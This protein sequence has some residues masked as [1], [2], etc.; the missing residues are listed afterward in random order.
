[1]APGIENGQGQDVT[2]HPTP[3]LKAHYQRLRVLSCEQL[4]KT[5]VPRFEAASPEERRALVS[6]IRAVG[7]VFSEAGS[8]S[9]KAEAREWMLRLLR[10]PEEKVR[11]YAILALPKLAS[12]E[13]EERA[14][15]ECLGGSNSAR[16]REALKTALER[17][18]GKATLRTQSEEALAPATLQRLKAN[19]ARRESPTSIR[20][21]DPVSLPMEMGIRLHCRRGIQEILREEVQSSTILRG[22]VRV[23]AVLPEEVCLKARRAFSLAELYSLRTFSAVGMVLGRVAGAGAE[24]PVEAL[25]E[26]IS[27]PG[28]E[29][30]LRS[31]TRGPLR[32]RLE[33][34]FKT[35][36]GSVVKALAEGIFERNPRLFND[37][38]QAPWEIRIQRAGGEY[39]VELTPKFR[40][41]PRFAYRQGDVP[42]ASHPPIAASLA[43]VAGV[44]EGETVWD[45]FCGSGLE[46]VERCR[47][48]G[49]SRVFG[50]DLS[51]DAIE[52]AR[53][54]LNAALA[55]PPEIL[56]RG[57]DFRKYAQVPQLRELSLI[58][59]NPPL[60]RRVPIPNLDQL[61][62]DL[63]EAASAVL[64]PGGF[65][66]FVNPGSVR[67]KGNRLKLVFRQKVDLGCFFCFLEKYERGVGSGRSGT[68]GGEA[69]LGLRGRESLVGSRKPGG[70]S[71]GPQGSRRNRR[72]GGP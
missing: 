42:A 66:V 14:L 48:G 68:L 37:P 20:F 2:A 40:P 30:I 63:F 58:L 45:P 43:R 22:R 36:R 7:V 15:L 47:L 51:S 32:Y 60:G 54:N 13:V 44:R 23:S 61:I 53:A 28:C 70:D 33:L 17:V 9:Q 24:V 5:E 72:E 10:D 41:D 19:I 1:M 18:G 31:F 55:E 21:E 50:T 3:S 34:G 52:T 16:E 4:W 49:V 59:T 11:R 65:L 62:E 25:A 6:I 64:K 67:P 56:L 27:A 26:L 38:R 71:R 29:R 8:D 12:S 57:M 46:L 69:G 39:T 35:P